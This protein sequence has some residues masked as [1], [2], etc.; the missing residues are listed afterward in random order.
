M[1]EA[2]AVLVGPLHRTMRVGP[3][4]TVS[5]SWSARSAYACVWAHLQAQGVGDHGG[6]AVRAERVVAVRSAGRLRPRPAGCAAARQALH[7]QLWAE[8]SFQAPFIFA[9]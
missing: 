9:R 5:S 7:T 4:S 8:K 1:L 6:H 2:E 3:S